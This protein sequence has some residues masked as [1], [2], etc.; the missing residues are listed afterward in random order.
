M[1]KPMNVPRSQGF[2]DRFQSSLVIQTRPLTLCIP[3]SGAC[4]PATAKASPK[5]NSATAMVVTSIPSISCGT[6]KVSRAAPVRP[7]MPTQAS[8]SPMK[9]EVK[10]RSVLSPKVAETVTK[11]STISAKYSRGPSVRASLT[12]CGARKARSSVAISPAT[13]LPMAA[14]ASAGPPLPFRAIWFPSIAVTI[15]ALSPGV[16]S[17]IEVVEPPYIPP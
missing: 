14:V 3:S 8:A 9:S 4:W 10:P 13:K 1:G 5:A 15:E 12:T 16:F 17:R 7:S 11:A 6:P 2:H